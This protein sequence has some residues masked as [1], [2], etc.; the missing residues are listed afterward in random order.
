MA[1]R[2]AGG[3]FYP[4]RAVDDEGEALDL[5]VQWRRDKSSSADNARKWRK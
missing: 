4:W 1:V 5:L 2:I 3:R